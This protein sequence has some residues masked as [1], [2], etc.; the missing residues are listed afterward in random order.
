MAS[1]PPQSVGGTLATSGGTAPAPSLA[2]N[3]LPAVDQKQSNR[4]SETDTIVQADV[5]CESKPHCPI[6]IYTYIDISIPVG[7]ESL[8]SDESSE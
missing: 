8:I 2:V 5:F 4:T 1:C 7:F 3:F 6:Q